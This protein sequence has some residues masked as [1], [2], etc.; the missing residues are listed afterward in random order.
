MIKRG[1]NLPLDLLKYET[2]VAMTIVVSDFCAGILIIFAEPP[3][4]SE[5]SKAVLLQ[6]KLVILKSRWRCFI[7][8]ALS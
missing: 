5:P 7:C 8:S 3:V 1:K 6:I 4:T 2:V